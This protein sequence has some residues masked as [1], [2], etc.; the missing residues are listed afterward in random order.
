[1]K[2]NPNLTTLGNLLWNAR[3]QRGLSANTVATAIGVH[4]ASIQRVERAQVDAPDPR[5]LQRWADYLDLDRQQILTLAGLDLRPS[6][7]V[8]LRQTTDLP[9]EA[10]AEAKT[11][12]QDLT[13][14]YGITGH[15]PE[16]GE[17]E[18]A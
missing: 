15:G 7:G 8:F 14:R 3:E 2:Q 5:I 13:A 1:M 10:I 9:P 11:Y 4:K 16:P 17:D 18:A 12:I 6:L